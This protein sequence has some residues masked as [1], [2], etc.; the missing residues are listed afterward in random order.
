MYMSLRHAM[1]VVVAAVVMLFGV[2]TAQAAIQQYEAIMD[3]LQEVP[4][5]ASPGSGLVTF[6]FDTVSNVLTLT[7]GNYQGLIAPVT[8]AHIHGPA[9]PGNNAGVI[10]PLGHTG[11]TAGMLSMSP[12]V[13]TMDQV[14]WLQGGLLYVNVHTSTFPGGE[15]RGQILLVPTPGALAAFGLAALISPRRRRR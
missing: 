6:D 15:I 9:A 2:S 8:A 3:G 13:L 1:K 14:G 11:G 10:I 7:S 5:N 12:A 4:P